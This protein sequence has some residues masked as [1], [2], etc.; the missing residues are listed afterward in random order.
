MNKS[1][2]KS[3]HLQR[4]S[5]AIQAGLHT[6]QWEL[7][8]LMTGGMSDASIYKIIVNNKEYAI[9]LDNIER[10]KFNLSRCYHNLKIVSDAG[11]APQVNYT[12]AEAGV[13]IMAFIKPVPFQVNDDKFMKA[14]AGTVRQLHELKNFQS[15]MSLLDMFNFLSSKISA[16]IKQ[17]KI[18]NDCIQYINK[19]KEIIL[20][21]NDVKPSHTDLNPSNILFDGAHIYF[22]DWLGSMPQNFYFDLACCQI[23]FYFRDECLSQQFVYYY[24][25]R[26]P[27]ENELSRLFF[28]KMFTYIYYGIVF[29]AFPAMLGKNTP[30]LSHEKLL[31]LP[32][33]VELMQGI[34]Q[35]K[36]NLADPMTQQECGFVFLKE[37]IKLMEMS[38]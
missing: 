30:A 19:I 38:S 8:S 32:S 17:E 36:V 24:F 16:E 23:F 21:P 9:K 13:V 6:Q 14:F 33:F 7:V 27:T 22:V 20:D 29:L 1:E 4:M 18:V 35:G 15:E 5:D 25:D 3:D 31:S 34:Q 2:L 11:I 37:A 26:S 28:M 12:N 10:K